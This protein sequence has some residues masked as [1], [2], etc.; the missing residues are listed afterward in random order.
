MKNITLLLTSCVF[1]L[2]TMVKAQ[3][4]PVADTQ[5][6]E[7]R[8]SLYGGYDFPNYDTNFKYIDYNGGVMGGA[9]ITKYWGWF[10]L[11][12]DANYINNSPKG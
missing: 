1:L 5:N 4:V 9:S 10:G 8:L 12:L 11:Q 3:E 7:I 2:A 6:K